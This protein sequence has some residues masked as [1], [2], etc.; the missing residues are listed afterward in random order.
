LQ[1]PDEPKIAHAALSRR[2]V[3]G[4]CVSKL[5]QRSGPSK[6]RLF[7]VWRLGEPLMSRTDSS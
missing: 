6:R 1:I 4:P 5:K 3:D 7:A 2:A